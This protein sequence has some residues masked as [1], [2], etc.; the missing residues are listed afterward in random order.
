M[1]GIPT[2]ILSFWP[3]IFLVAAGQSIFF[4]T[5]LM[6]SRKE[7]PS[8]FYLAV[9]L[10]LFGYM[11]FFNFG[12]W[13][14]FIYQF[15]HLFYT[16]LPLNYLFGPL[17]LLYLDS[18]QPKPKLQKWWWLH[19]VPVLVYV[20]YMAPFFLQSG[21][22][23]LANITGATP[24][25]T[26]LFKSSHFLRHMG[27]FNVFGGHLLIY[28]VW[29]IYW[30]FQLMQPTVTNHF[31]AETNIIRKKWLQLL[32]VLYGAFMFSYLTYFLIA[33]QPFF[34]LAHD[35]LICSIMTISIYSIGYLGYKR[36]LIFSGDLFRKTFLKEKKYAS[37]SLTTTAA[38]SIEKALLNF[39]QVEKPYLNND[40]K[41]KD[42][43]D[44]LNT[45]PHHL[46]QV[47][48]EKFGKSFNQYINEL[49]IQEAQQLL[50]NPAHE[51]TYIIQIAYQ[52]GFNNKTTFNA[53]FKKMV[54]CSPRQFRTQ[55]SIKKNIT[56]S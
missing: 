28:F 12:Y 5:L 15:P 30:Y 14:N 39:I 21:A 3:I 25:P 54:G 17:L 45:S 46:S 53:A 7:N 35:F 36:P 19:F 38:Q 40:L 6:S 4:S 47:I 33:D 44:Q 52:V 43:A 41:M 22:T 13:T 55:L 49:R 24:F 27:R 18:L 51:K 29:K 11:L 26:P 23:K 8:N 1:E 31:S 34:L 42:L 10:C 50:A 16:N 56:S 48:N 9:F 2:V 32:I 37:S 20:L